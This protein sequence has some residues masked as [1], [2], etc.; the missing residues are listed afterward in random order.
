MIFS[1]QVQNE[2]N[3]MKTLFFKVDGEPTSAEVRI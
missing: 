1:S 2:P 3:P